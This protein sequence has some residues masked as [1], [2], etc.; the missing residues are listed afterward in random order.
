LINISSIENVKL[1]IESRYDLYSLFNRVKIYTN[2]HEKF[3][4]FFYYGSNYQYYSDLSFLLTSLSSDFDFPFINIILNN[5]DLKMMRLNKV[6]CLLLP[7]IY[8]QIINKNK[9]EMIILTK[10]IIEKSGYPYSDFYS[11]NILS[12]FLTLFHFHSNIE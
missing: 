9:E 2:F 11:N 4:L 8:N 3:K 12:N 5:I 6:S 7:L 1:F 10:R